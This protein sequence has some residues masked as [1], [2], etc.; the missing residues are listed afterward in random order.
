M[1]CW[2]LAAVIPSIHYQDLTDPNGAGAI[3]MDPFSWPTHYPYDEPEPAHSCALGASLFWALGGIRENWPELNLQLQ[4]LSDAAV[5]YGRVLVH[6]NS[7][8]PNNPWR[9]IGASVNDSDLEDLIRHCDDRFRSYGLKI[10]W[11][12]A[13]GITG[14]ETE[15]KQNTLVDRICSAL[16]DR[17]DNVYYCEMAN[18]YVVN[19][20]T[21]HILRN[22]ARRTRQHLPALERLSLSSPNAVHNGGDIPAE[23]EKMYSGCP[24]ANAITP[25]WDRYINRPPDLGPFAPSIVIC[26]EPRGPMS[27]V[28]QTDDPSIIVGDYKAAAEAGYDSYVLHGD[29]LIWSKYISPEPSNHH[30]FWPVFTDHTNG[31]EILDAVKAFRLSGTISDG[32]GGGGG[33][34]PM[35]PY[36]ENKS[37]EFGLAC[38]DVYAESGAPSDPGMV[39]VHSSRAA[40]DFYVGGLTWEDSMHKH[41]N[42]FRAV[43]GLPPI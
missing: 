22:M 6:L 23:V 3:W 35:I 41:I 26:N 7:D 25:H 15:D 17:L 28:A 4:Q 19:G 9:F 37:I 18:E 39:S 13:G 34:E 8:D 31:Q 12:F 38:N 1:S 36:D 20:L 27:S 42:E 29:S 33:E 10:G 2:G 32:G 5:D 40:W 11:T 14:I 30:G 24:E 21:T 43:Y 16:A